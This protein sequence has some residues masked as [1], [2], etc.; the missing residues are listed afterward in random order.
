MK[1][2]PLVYIGLFAHHGGNG[3][4]CNRRSLLH[5]PKILFLDEPTI[6]DKHHAKTEGD[7]CKDR[8]A[9]SYEDVFKIQ[10]NE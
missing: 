4:E 3:S 2:L 9:K 6:N 7:K 10:N 5:R 1:E 8:F